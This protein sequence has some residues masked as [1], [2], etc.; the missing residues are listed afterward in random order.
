MLAERIIIHSRDVALNYVVF[1]LYMGFA[2]VFGSTL[3]STRVYLHQWTLTSTTCNRLPEG[4]YD[5][6]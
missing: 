6:I 5:P 1:L 3:Y 4:R 2:I